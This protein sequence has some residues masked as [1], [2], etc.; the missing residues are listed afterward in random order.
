MCNVNNVFYE[1]VVIISLLQIFA[2]WL[3][4]ICNPKMREENLDVEYML[5]PFF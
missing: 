5:R 4:C 2:C 1:I 3:S